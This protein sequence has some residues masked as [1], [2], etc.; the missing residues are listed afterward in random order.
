MNDHGITW[1]FQL[2]SSSEPAD[3]VVTCVPLLAS[4]ETPVEGVGTAA[5]GTGVIVYD[6]VVEPAALSCELPPEHT[7]E[8]VAVTEVTEGTSEYVT[9]A[10]ADAVHPLAPVPTTV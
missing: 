4:V 9:A 3:S 5:N 1:L 6:V 10:V 2:P 8:G 7:A